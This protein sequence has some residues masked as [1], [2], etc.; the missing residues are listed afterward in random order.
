MMRIVEA[1]IWNIQFEGFKQKLIDE[2]EEKYGEEIRAKYGED[3]VEKSNQKI[4]NM[5][6]KQYDKISGLEEN[7]KKTLAEAFKT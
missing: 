4:K 7:I 6:E 3:T 1:A 5:T 2:N